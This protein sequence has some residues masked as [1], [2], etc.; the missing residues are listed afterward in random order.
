MAKPTVNVLTGK[1]TFPDIIFNNTNCFMRNMSKEC[2]ECQYTG[3]KNIHFHIMVIGTNTSTILNIKPDIPDHAR[4]YQKYS[5]IELKN[6][7]ENSSYTMSGYQRKQDTYQNSTVYLMLQ[8]GWNDNK[9]YDSQQNLMA[10]ALCGWTWPTP[11]PTI[12]S[13]GNPFV[14]NPFILNPETGIAHNPSPAVTNAQSAATINPSPSTS[15]TGISSSGPSV[16][17]DSNGAKVYTP[18]PANNSPSQGPTKTVLPSTEVKYNP[19]PPNP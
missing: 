18:V 3:S 7:V 4:Y 1:I 14:P 10:S 2:S 6:A 13:T 16:S 8:N 19:V 15:S 5:N 12:V 9:I 11:D 17:T